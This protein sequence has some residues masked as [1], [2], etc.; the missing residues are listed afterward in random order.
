[1]LKIFERYKLKKHLRSNQ[2]QQAIDILE[3]KAKEGNSNAAFRMGL[4]YSMS[5]TDINDNDAFL[6]EK[7]FA[8]AA[9]ADHVQAQSMLGDLYAM[10]VNDF[11]KLNRALKWYNK[12]RQHGDVESGRKL[13]CLYMCNRENIN[14]EVNAT[15]LLLEAAYKGDYKS[16]VLLAWCYKKGVLGLSADLSRFQYWWSKIKKM[17]K[18]YNHSPSL[19]QLTFS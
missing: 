2:Y 15:G 11:V 18:I 3:P 8:K 5:M 1:M 19:T 7:W 16:A 14:I 13:A 10:Q 12:A 17:K 9:M 6:A 4:I